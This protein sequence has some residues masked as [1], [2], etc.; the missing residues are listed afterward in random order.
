MILFFPAETFAVSLSFVSFVFSGWNAAVYLGGEIPAPARVVL[1]RAH[2]HMQNDDHD[3][4]LSVITDFRV[5]GGP[6]PRRT[7]PTPG[8]IITRT[9]G[10]SP[11]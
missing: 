7:L 8:A 6:I 11:A 1:S 3:Q 10:F 2:E 4:A 9:S 5:R